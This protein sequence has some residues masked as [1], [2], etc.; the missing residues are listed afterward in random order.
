MPAANNVYDVVV[1]VADGAFTDTQALAVSVTNVAGVTLNGTA[2][3]DNLTGTARGGPAQRPGS[4]NDTLIG[5]AGNDTLDGGLGSD[6]M[7]GGLGD[8]TYQVEAAGDVS[9]EAAGAGPRHGAHHA[10]QLHAAARTSRT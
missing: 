4:S 2:A 7:V 6:S 10:H 5:G 8:D 1:Q 3:A 9:S